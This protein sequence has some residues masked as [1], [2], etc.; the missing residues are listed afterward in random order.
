MGRIGSKDSTNILN[1]KKRKML[2][3]IPKRIREWKETTQKKMD[4]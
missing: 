4:K 1:M 2:A 3:K